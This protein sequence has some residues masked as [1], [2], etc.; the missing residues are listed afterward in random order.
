M[1]FDDKNKF[2]KKIIN[3]D[4]PDQDFDSQAFVNNHHYVKIDAK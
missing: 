2:V 3:N 1:P 4:L